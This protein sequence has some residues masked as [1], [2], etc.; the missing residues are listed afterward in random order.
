ME[1]IQN[2]QRTYPLRHPHSHHPSKGPTAPRKVSSF[3]SS[4]GAIWWDDM[5]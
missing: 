2:V 3:T 4:P 1:Y 5:K